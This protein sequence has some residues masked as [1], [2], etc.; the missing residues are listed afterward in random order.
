M[1][2]PLY[3]WI[4]CAMGLHGFERYRA[5]QDLKAKYCAEDTSYTQSVGSVLRK[6]FL[7][8]H[9]GEGASHYDQERLEWARS[10]GVDISEAAADDYVGQYGLNGTKP[11]WLGRLSTS[12]CLYLDLW[13]M[14]ELAVQAG[15][16]TPEYP[17][18]IEDWVF[19]F[20]AQIAAI[21]DGHPQDVV[22]TYQQ[23]LNNGRGYRV[24]SPRTPEPP[25]P[26]E[27][28]API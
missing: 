2:I 26:A 23:W 22:P 16:Q 21:K 9:C 5:Y 25:H 19:Y 1:P 12:E 24:S 14:R 3:E 10:M 8:K 11:K 27:D 28:E 7:M 4:P 17:P 6:V 18:E 20:S 13:T 15:R